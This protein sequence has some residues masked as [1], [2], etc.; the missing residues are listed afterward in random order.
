MLLQSVL[1]AWIYHRIFAGSD[2]AAGTLIGQYALLGAALSWTFATL[3]VAGA[4]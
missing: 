3:A 2:A 1:F 4:G